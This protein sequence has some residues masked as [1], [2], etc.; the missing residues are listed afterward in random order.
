M[1]LNEHLITFY[2]CLHSHLSQHLYDCMS[3]VALLVSKS[4]YTCQPACALTERRQHRYDREEVRT[5]G[6]IHTE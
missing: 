2:L 5:V 1:S 3:P 6:C 4:A